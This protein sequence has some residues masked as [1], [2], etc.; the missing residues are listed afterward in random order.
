MPQGDIPPIELQK[1]WLAFEDN[2]VLADVSFQVGR[3]ET[4]VLLGVTGSGKSVLLKTVLGL[5]KPDAGKILIDGRDMVP[6]PEEQL[7]DFR[8]RMGIV[9]QEGALFDSLSMLEN[10][11]DRLREEGL[12]DETQI[13]RRVRDVLGFVEMEQAIDKM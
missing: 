13:E 1:V 8:R 10:V 6:L 5:V 3:G 12:S 11:A 2:Q 9:F 4:L 7:H